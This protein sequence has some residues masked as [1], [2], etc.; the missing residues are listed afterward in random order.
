MIADGDARD[1]GADRGDDSRD[2]VAEYRGQLVSEVI[3]HH[4]Q[5]A[6][7]QATGLH[8]DEDLAANGL[9]DVDV[10]NLEWRTDLG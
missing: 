7:A 8:A 2:L 5:V 6:V 10:G 4:V 3:F 1:I 9:S